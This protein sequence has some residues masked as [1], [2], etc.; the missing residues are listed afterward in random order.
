MDPDTAKVQELDQWMNTV[1]HEDHHGKSKDNMVFFRGG[2]GRNNDSRGGTL[3]PTGIAGGAPFAG[4]IGDKDAWYVGAGF[5]FNIN[6]NL[7]GMMNGTEVLGELMFDYKQLGERKANGL[8]AAVTEA[9]NPA[10]KGLSVNAQSATVNALTLAA[11]PKIKFFKGSNFR[12]WLIPAGMEITV[13][14]PPSDAITVLNP[15]MMF[16]AGADYKI[17]KDI[18]AGADV[19]YHHSFDTVDGVNSDG[20]TAGGY[21]GLG[22]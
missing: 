16:G 3:D 5:D 7:F 20:L 6:D 15:G 22:F 12:P 2:Y 1:K 18:Y 13:I 4:A 8:T 14:S 19:R 11:S 21:L 9:V 10:L 17:W